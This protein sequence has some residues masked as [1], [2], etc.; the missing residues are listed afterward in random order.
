M[1]VAVLLLGSC[2]HPGFRVLVRTDNSDVA[3]VRVSAGSDFADFAYEAVPGAVG[4]ARQG[5]GEFHGTI[6]FLTSDCEVVAT[7]ELSA[8]GDVLVVIAPD[9]S[10]STSTVDSPGAPILLVETDQCVRR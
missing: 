9:A 10:V 2:G 7:T 6:E 4:S 1:L 8:I 3:L 5:T